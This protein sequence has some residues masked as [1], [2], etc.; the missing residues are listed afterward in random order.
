MDFK[1]YYKILGVSETASGKEIKQAFRKLA[2]KYHPDKNPGD[3]SS[4]QRFKDV[5]EANEI[6]T[7]PKKRQKYEALRT[8]WGMYGNPRKSGQ[9]NFNVGRRGSNVRTMTPEEM[10]NLF[11]GTGSGSDFFSTF[12]GSQFG[13][14][15]S[16]RGFRSPKNQP[17]QT[18]KDYE[19]KLT[20]EEAYNGVTHRLVV[21]ESNQS[22]TLDVKIPSGVNEGS[23]IRVL[24]KRIPNS[25]SSTGQEIYLRVRLIPHSIFQ[26]KGNDLHINVL[27]ELTTVVL[28]GTVEVP[29]ISGKSVQ[30]KIPPLTKQDQ[31][32][33]LKGYGM[34][35]ISQLKNKGD[36]YAKIQIKLPTKLTKEERQHYQELDRLNKSKSI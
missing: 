14:S 1:D 18:N 32:F 20:L 36:A 19:L 6:L 7:D 29:T 16:M 11:K 21:N 5:N 17:S 4:E 10:E 28:G 8:N 34:P 22:R 35:V 27:V 31:L 12:F 30:L 25:S 26:R 2:R 24:G 3:S 15:Q 23:R 9:G 33:R 13:N